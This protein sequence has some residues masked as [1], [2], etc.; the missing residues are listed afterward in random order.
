MTLFH[1]RPRA[2][3]NNV[4]HSG[5]PH[6][7][8][9]RNVA[10]LHASAGKCA[11]LFDRMR[12]ERGSWILFAVHRLKRFQDALIKGVEHVVSMRTLEQM[13][14]V[15][16]NAIVAL[17]ADVCAAADRRMR[18]VLR[19]QPR[20]TVCANVA[21]CSSAKGEEAVAVRSDGAFPWPALILASGCEFG[22]EPG[23]VGMT[24]RLL[25]EGVGH[26]VL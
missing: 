12:R 22:V 3:M 19:Q 13:V 20:N 24:Q 1:V 2:F 11:N 23:N 16:A 7:K 9:A 17:V 15:Y 4:P 8:L 14:R 5:L 26:A 10:L 25:R 21:V 18:A 6:A